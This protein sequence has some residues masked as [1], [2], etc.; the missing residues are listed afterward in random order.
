MLTS[1][2]VMSW[3][4]PSVLYSIFHQ[5]GPGSP[6]GVGRWEAGSQQ[7]LFAEPPLGTDAQV[8]LQ[9]LGGCSVGRPGA[10]RHGRVAVQRSR[11]FYRELSKVGLPAG[12]VA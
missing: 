1:H 8:T 11:L 6:G 12:V 4:V 3:P 10:N 7:A 2:V 5:P 9:E